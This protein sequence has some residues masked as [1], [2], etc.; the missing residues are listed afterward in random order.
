MIRLQHQIRR[1]RPRVKLTRREIFARDRHTCQYC[2]RQA[3]DLTLDHVLP[4]HRGGGAHVGEPRHRLQ[5]VQPP[6]GRP[7]PRGGARPPDA[8]AVRAA[9]R[10]LLAVHAR[11][12]RTSATRPGGRTSSSAG[13]EAGR[14]RRRT[15]PRRRTV[16]RPRP[17]RRR[18]GPRSPA[19]HGHAGLRRRRLA[20][21]RPPRSRAADWDLATDAPPG[22]GRWSCFPGAVYE[23][24]FGT[25]AV[26]RDG[27]AVRDH[28]VPARARVRG[29]SGGRTGW[30]SATTSRPTSP[31]ATS[32]ST[33]WPG[34][35][36]QRP[37][38]RGRR[39]DPEDPFGGLADLGG[40]ILR[41]VGDPEARFQEDA[42]RMVRAV[43]LAATLDFA[44]EPATLAAIAA[45]AGLVAHLSGER[46]GA[47]LERLL[48]APRPSVGLRLA[49]DTGL[50]AV[51]APELAA[52]RGIPQNK[53]PGRGPLGPH[54][55]GRGRGARRP[56][57]RPAGGAAPRHRQAGDARRR[58]FHHH[59]VVGARMAGAILRRLR[60]PR[61]TIED[62]A[63]LV[64]NHMF[65]VGP[66]AGGAAVRRFIKRIGP[67]P[68]TRC[69]RCGGP[70]T[71]AAAL[72][73]DDP[74]P[75]RV[76]GPPRRRA[77]GAR[78]RSTAARSR[79]TATT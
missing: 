21:R 62:V 68:S 38:E 11:T 78:S 28:D 29:P 20:A 44:I 71:S 66:D 69:S 19:R 75:A 51:V 50:L 47:E 2:G 52:Q 9:Q 63:H 32:R 5:A 60:F 46:V 36:R 27:R 35:A 72:A 40:R 31:A 77:R 42:L 48:E 55:A 18:G 25:V 3:N 49:A 33:R 59:D 4:R 22:A 37:T 34:A 74:V 30:S 17:R 1:P 58:H 54:A 76:P 45:N 24:R 57:R 43:R 56:S 23:N 79:S 53:I 65:T 26:R 41:A 67:R 64:R 73:P 7:D 16:S 13:A 15:P 12:S 14:G 10:H 39:R 61:S 70:T 6:Q 8:A